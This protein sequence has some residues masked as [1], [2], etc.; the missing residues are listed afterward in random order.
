M[1]HWRENGLN[2]KLQETP[3]QVLSCEYCDNFKSTYFEK[4]LERAASLNPL[5]L[6]RYCKKYVQNLSVPFVMR[7]LSGSPFCKNFF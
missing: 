2:S 4:D 5:P 7:H 6:V 3:A 1:E